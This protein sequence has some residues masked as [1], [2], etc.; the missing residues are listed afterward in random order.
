LP[1]DVIC[2]EIQRALLNKNKKDI[3]STDS[4]VHNMADRHT[5]NFRPNK[6]IQGSHAPKQ[7]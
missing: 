4:L 1:F 2:S 3:Q 5:T 6:N 7:R